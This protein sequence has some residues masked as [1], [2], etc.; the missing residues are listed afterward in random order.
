VFPLES[1][2]WVDYGWQ[3]R[4]ITSARVDEKG[5]YEIRG[6]PRGDYWIVAVDDTV[7][8]AWNSPELF[9]ALSR[10]AERLRVADG[11]ARAIDLTART[12]VK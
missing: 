2:R 4:E 1:K 7:L 6:L 10:I 9:N 5:R 12:L 8:A 3:P 11:E